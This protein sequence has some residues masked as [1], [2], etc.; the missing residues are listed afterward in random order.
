MTRNDKELP[1]M[2]WDCAGMPKNGQKWPAIF[3]ENFSFQVFYEHIV[4]LFFVTIVQDLFKFGARCQRRLMR[5][6]FYVWRLNPSAETF[7]SNPF[8]F[9]TSKT[10][11]VFFLNRNRIMET[12]GPAEG[13][14][15]FFKNDCYCTSPQFLEHR[16]ITIFF[17]KKE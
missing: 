15:S 17:L 3:W 11:I 9:F 10:K 7:C 12:N 14:N 13:R 8:E 2:T 4:Q 16:V 1:G 5:K 6:A